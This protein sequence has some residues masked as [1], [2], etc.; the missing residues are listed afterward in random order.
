MREYENMGMGM[1]E[2]GNL[3]MGELRNLSNLNF[4]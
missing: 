4:R 2:W 1:K 3:R